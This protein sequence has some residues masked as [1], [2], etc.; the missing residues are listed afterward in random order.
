VNEEIAAL[1]LQPRATQPDPRVWTLAHAVA[2]SPIVALVQVLDPPHVQTLVP[3]AKGL[4][5]PDPAHAYQRLQRRYRV[6]QALKGELSGE[7]EVDAAL[8]QRELQAHR[9]RVLQNRAMVVTVPVLT[10]ALPETPQPG[11]KVLVLL[12]Q[13]AAGLEFVA[14]NAVLHAEMLDVVRALLAYGA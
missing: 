8:W 3:V 14:Q 1:A 7:V 13:T 5:L 10:D 6:E 11:E 12:R 2:A 9:V 4:S